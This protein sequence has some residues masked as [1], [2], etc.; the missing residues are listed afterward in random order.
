MLMKKLPLTLTMLF[1]IFVSVGQTLSIGRRQ[2]I[3][4]AKYFKIQTA[5]DY[6]A[7]SEDNKNLDQRLSCFV[8]ILLS[9]KAKRGRKSH[10]P[11]GKIRLL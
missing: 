8:N 6:F 4:E 5:G 3:F 9:R 1:T 10:K 2:K 7:Q 11:D